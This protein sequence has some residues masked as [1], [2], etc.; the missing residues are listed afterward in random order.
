[1]NRWVVVMLMACAS[2]VLA[3]EKDGFEV[4]DR[5]HLADVMRRVR[6]LAVVLGVQR[7]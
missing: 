1:M 2:S 6:R 7:M 5:K 3:Q 4:H